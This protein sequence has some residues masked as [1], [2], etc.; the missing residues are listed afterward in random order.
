MFYKE[1]IAG[2]PVVI[3]DIETYRD[4]DTL[5]AT[6][7]DDGIRGFV[8]VP[9]MEE[10]E[11]VGVLDIGLADGM[12]LTDN[13]LEFVTSL[14]QP[15]ASGFVRARLSR[16]RKHVVNR[17]RLLNELSEKILI[18]LDLDSIARIVVDFVSNAIQCDM[19]TIFPS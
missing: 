14:L 6:V 12:A 4:G 17:L 11:L 5:L 16:D 2:K 1:L 15:V 7:F 9:I 8:F 19:A 3:P 10:N 13:H 18:D